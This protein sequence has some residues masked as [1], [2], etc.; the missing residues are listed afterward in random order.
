MATVSISFHPYSI[1]REESAAISAGT[2]VTGEAITTGGT[3][4]VS[5]NSCPTNNQ[6]VRLAVTGGDVWVS[7]G[8]DPEAAEGQDF[9]LIG[10][11][12]EYFYVGFGDKVAVIDA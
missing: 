11:T 7:I 12:T 3:S 6:V 10:G 8:E 5:T 2:G 9:L 4:S 1:L